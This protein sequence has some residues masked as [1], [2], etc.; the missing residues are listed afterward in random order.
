MMGR[1]RKHTEAV[2]ALPYDFQQT[3]SR[4][5]QAGIVSWSYY[6]SGREEDIRYVGC[7][8][9]R[10]VA[11]DRDKYAQIQMTLLKPSLGPGGP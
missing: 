4:K 5:P 9:E 3:K 2:S 8:M 11:T 10:G 1:W 6:S 7:Q